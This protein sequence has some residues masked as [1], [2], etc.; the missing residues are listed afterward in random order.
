MLDD[1]KQSPSA[2]KTPEPAPSA[3]DFR[4]VAAASAGNSQHESPSRP[5]PAER[6]TVRQRIWSDIAFSIVTA[7]LLILAKEFLDSKTKAGEQLELATYGWLQHQLASLEP[8]AELPLVIVDLTDTKPKKIKGAQ[9]G[10]QATPRDTLLSLLTT[11]IV[12]KN[13]RAVGIDVDLSPLHDGRLPVTPGDYKFFDDCLTLQEK[14]PRS[15]IYLGVYRTVVL[16]RK[17]WLGPDKYQSLAA[18]I[19]APRHEV[20]KMVSCIAAN[21][22]ETCEA[23][24]LSGLLAKELPSQPATPRKHL[25]DRFPRIAERISDRRLT[26]DLSVGLFPVD[27]SQLHRLMSHD[28]TFPSGDPKIVSTFPDFFETKIVLVGDANPDSSADKFVVPGEPEPVPGIYIQASAI[29]TLSQA[30]LY[31]LTDLG[32]WVVDLG[33]A[34]LVIVAISLIRWFHSGRTTREVAHHRIEGWLILVVVVVCIIVG[35]GFVRKHRILWTDFVLAIFALLLHPTGE[36]YTKGI[37]KWLGKVLPV[38]WRRVVFEDAGKGPV[39]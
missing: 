26:G 16:P 1:P 22:A 19:L 31:E 37:L 6:K 7:I 9:K 8:D 30:P 18:S 28:Y 4:L 27:Y 12:K 39:A 25:A 36:K 32:R 13:A 24:T 21:G 23:D 2:E 3:T 29:Y 35:A 38:S 20:T 10:E 14:N 34:F 11:L 5:S 17:N 15:K 33:L